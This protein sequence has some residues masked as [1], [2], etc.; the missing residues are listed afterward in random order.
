M[1]TSIETATDDEL[2]A[3]VDAYTTAIAEHGEGHPA[4]I[5]MARELMVEFGFS[6]EQAEAEA[7]RRY[8]GTLG[9]PR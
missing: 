8:A 5:Q 4:T 9:A 6:P 2:S 7:V 1:N 3:C